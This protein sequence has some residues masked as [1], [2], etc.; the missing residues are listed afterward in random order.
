MKKRIGILAVFMMA[1]I[2]PLPEPPRVYAYNW[3]EDFDYCVSDYSNGWFQ[4]WETAWD[5]QANCDAMW[6]PSQYPTQNQQ[7]RQQA[8]SNK[9]A[10]LS[11]STAIFGSCSSYVPYNYEAFD[12][13]T[14]AVQ[15]AALCSAQF[16]GMDN[17]EAYMECRAESK[18]DLCQ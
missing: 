6:P 15:A 5:A 7:C 1:L 10:C 3:V 12:F 4:C 14:L 16:Q 9:G 2:W 17:F 11:T 13:C 8:N 18:I